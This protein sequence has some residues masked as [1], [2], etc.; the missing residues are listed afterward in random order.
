M[1]DF[2]L[3]LEFKRAQ[4][5]KAVEQVEP[6]D[7]VDGALALSTPSLPRVWELNLVL[8]PQATDR[9]TIERLLAAAERLQAAAGHLHRKV[10]LSEPGPADDALESLAT[11]AGWACERD[12]VMVRRRPPDKEPAGRVTVREITEEELAPPEDRFLRAGPEGKD[13]EIRRQLIAQN[14]RWARGATVARRI[15]V[16]EDGAVVAWCRL[17]DDG[18]VTEIDAVGVLPDR[19][20]EGFGRALLEG[21]LSRVPGDRML[22]LCADTEDW[23]KHLYGQARVR[24]GWRTAGRDGAPE[25]GH[26]HALR[27]EERRVGRAGDSGAA[28]VI[29]LQLPELPLGS[30]GL[31][32]GA[33]HD[34]VER[35]GE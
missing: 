32:H 17:W 18:R 14:E 5:L 28:A 7:E 3:A 26:E 10:R 23:P 6:I 9:D 29:D 11:A 20:G 27:H 30:L 19:R 2:Q 8:A 21:A 31:D 35:R 13:D 15:G 1:T 12:L 24:R 33:R 22:F 16:V 34:C 4:L 25:L